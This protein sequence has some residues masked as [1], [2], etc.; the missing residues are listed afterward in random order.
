MLR[1]DETRPHPAFDPEAVHLRPMVA[2]D[3]DQVMVIE[4]SFSAPWT[5][6][7]FSQELHQVEVSA[8]M[9]AQIG[10]RVAGYVLWW[11]VVDEVHI[12]NLAVHEVFRRRG[13]ARRLLSE[14]F[15]RAGAR[16]MSIATLEVR[17][18]NEPA[19][20]LYES[21]GF[22]KIAIRKAYYADN[23]EDA[24]VMLKSLRPEP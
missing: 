7:M 8:S 3:L 6:E 21:I 16:G 14:V 22:K 12:V 17:I 9:V 23:G 10:D 24:L 13:V 2:R 19:I 11:Y 4:R 1:S 5:R 15:E 18:H 20:R